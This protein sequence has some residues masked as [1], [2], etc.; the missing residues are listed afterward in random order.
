MKIVSSMSS[1]HTTSSI[2]K[3]RSGGNVILESVLTLLPTFALPFCAM[4]FR[5]SA[6]QNA[7]RE[8]VRHAITFQHHGGLGQTGS[9]STVV[10]QNAVGLVKSTD[11]PQHVFIAHL[12][13]ALTN[14]SN[15]PG[16]WR[17]R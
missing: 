15:T 14:G 1:H 11:C 7:V 12:N 13:P 5:W 9:I 6:L 17:L 16:N 2:R 3:R 10:E 4:T 8:G